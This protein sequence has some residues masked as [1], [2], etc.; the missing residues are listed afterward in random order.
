M[1]K[2]AVI[3]A[4]GP[5]GP[6]ASQAPAAHPLLVGTLCYLFASIFWGVNVP[7]T[8]ILFHTFDPFFL[9]P[10]RV[11][12]AA[13]VLLL[14]AM[15]T[16]GWRAALVPIRFGRFA[17]MTGSLA[18]F[19]LLYNLGLKYTHPITAAAIMAATPVYAAVTLRLITGAPL[20]NGFWGAAALTVIGTGIAIYGRASSQGQGLQ[21][22]GG[23]LLI[24]LSY[25]CWNLY[26]ICAQ[27]WFAPDIAQVRR[28]YAAMAGAVAWLLL[29]WAAVR[30]AGL[31]G[32]PNLAPGGEA[33]AWLLV[34]AVFATGLSVVAWNIGVNRIGLAAGSLWQNTVP[35]FA[36]LTSMLFGFVPTPAQA[37]G[38]AI[39][40]A[41]VIYM[42]W[43]KAR[44]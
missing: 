40:I 3:R 35:V 5:D 34:T 37:L 23:E 19:F 14:V 18:G 26:S 32:P 30:T 21:L 11:A 20:E 41:G 6:G 39:V 17:L 43:R 8:S 38:G 7:L 33:I 36:V 15:A 13:L 2:S 16:L 9:A 31:V 44:G 22:Q 25:A 28:T 10:L 24:V 27:R 12:L 1:T 42:Q 29:G 4:A